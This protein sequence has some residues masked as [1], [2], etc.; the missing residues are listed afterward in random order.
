MSMSAKHL[1]KKYA[2][3]VTSPWC[4]TAQVTIAAGVVIVTAASPQVEGAAS[5]IVLA[6]RGWAT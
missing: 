3:F 2:T 5:G 4:T 1:P 6:T